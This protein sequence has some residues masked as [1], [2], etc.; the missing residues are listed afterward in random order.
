MQIKRSQGIILKVYGADVTEAQKLSLEQIQEDFANDKD[1]VQKAK[2]NTL[3]DFK[4][5]YV[6]AFMDKA[7]DRMST[8]EKFFAKILDDEELRT[9]LKKDMLV[10]TY[11]RLR[12]EA[13]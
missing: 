12:E 7:V 10:G 4:L 8:N 9:M 3:E 11:N 5:A 13:V 2:S 6:K 1:M